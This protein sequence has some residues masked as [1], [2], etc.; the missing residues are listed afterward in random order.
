MVRALLIQAAIVM[1]ILA[2]IRW[3]HRRPSR[4]QR[5]L[6]VFLRYPDTRWRASDMARLA[7]VSHG[8]ILQHLW[9]LEREGWLHSEWEADT[10]PWDESGP[11]ARR[12]LYWLN[13]AHADQEVPR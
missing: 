2:L 7:R 12:R 9:L 6:D 3:Q 4:R 13:R 10:T 1:A 8:S 11:R 5:V